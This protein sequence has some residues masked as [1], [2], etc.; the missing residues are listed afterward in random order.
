MKNKHLH[1]LFIYLTTSIC[2]LQAQVGVGTTTPEGALDVSST[3]NGFIPPRVA[4]LTS[5]TTP[6]ITNPQGGALVRGTMVYNTTNGSGFTPGYYYWETTPTVASD[7]WIRLIG[8]PKTDWSLTGNTGTTAGTNFVG[9]TDDQDL[10]FKTQGTDRLNLSNTT[11]QLQ[12]YYAGAAATPAYSWNSDPD[13]GM[14]HPAVNELSLSTGGTEG[15]RIDANSNV[16]IGKTVPVQRLHLGNNIAGAEIIRV[17]DYAVTAGSTNAGELATTNTSTGKALYSDANGDLKVRYVYGDN[18]Q[19]TILAAGTQN[20]TTTALTDITGAT[21][22][23]TPRHSTVY[24]SFAI[25]GY[26]PLSGAN[27]RGWIVVN[28]DR[29]GTNVGNFLNLNATNDG[30]GSSGAA[31]VSAGNFPISVT[32]GVSVIIKLRGRVSATGNGNFTIDKT[33]YTSYMTILD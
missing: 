24:L 20:I 21:I 12:S 8:G 5:L 28:V 27:P 30:S 19:S 29:G 26:N 6:T 7:T 13:T 4:L 3:T 14:L 16:G 18:T 11:G 23:F 33:N 10:R 17:E 25:S 9:T 15:M 1:I 32:P 2:S 31:T 22:T